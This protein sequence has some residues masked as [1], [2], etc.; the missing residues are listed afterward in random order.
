L[1]RRD[2]SRVGF[3]LQVVTVRHLWMFLVNPLEVPAELVEYLA[4]QLGIAD[5]SCVKR[6]LSGSLTR[7]G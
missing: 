2:Y 4:E 6:Y 3:A 7:H 1:R 5:P